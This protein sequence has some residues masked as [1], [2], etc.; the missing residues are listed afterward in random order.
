M[1][2]C[3]VGNKRNG[4]RKTKA[5]YAIVPPTM[6]GDIKKLRNELAALF[7][8]AREAHTAYDAYYNEAY[9]AARDGAR[10]MTRY[11]QLF[12]DMIAAEKRIQS[13]FDMAIYA[14]RAGDADAICLLTAYIAVTDRH[15]RSA[16]NKVVAA[17]TLRSLPL[18][19]QQG[20]A[21]VAAISAASV[22]AGE[23]ERQELAY[24][25][26]HIEEHVLNAS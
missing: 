23:A 2:S 20:T 24:L 8:A 4:F 3:T 16:D 19:A 7:K 22:I 6:T 11:Q 21:I 15:F 26:L 9:M 14:S 17:R 25:H 5:T 1:V 13:R 10:D 12:E 18:T